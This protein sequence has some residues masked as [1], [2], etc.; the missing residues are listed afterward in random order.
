VRFLTV[1]CSFA[2]EMQVIILSL[3]FSSLLPFLHTTLLQKISH[4]RKIE[5]IMHDGE[6]GERRG[7]IIEFPFIC[8]TR[9]RGSDLSIVSQ[10]SKVLTR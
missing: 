5:E 7:E 9:L 2:Y 3:L 4:K 8:F 1:R 10:V 6:R